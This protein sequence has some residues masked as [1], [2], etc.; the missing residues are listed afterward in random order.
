MAIF[1][2][3]NFIVSEKI[4][5]YAINIETFVGCILILELSERELEILHCC[6]FFMFPWYLIFYNIGN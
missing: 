4:D 1:I 5:C 2:S 6:G 3:V